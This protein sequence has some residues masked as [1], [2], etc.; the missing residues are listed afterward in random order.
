MDMTSL[1]F[2]TQRCTFLMG[3]YSQRAESVVLRWRPALDA[4]SGWQRACMSEWFVTNLEQQDEIISYVSGN[5]SYARAHLNFTRAPER[6]MLDYMLQSTVM[7]IVSWL[8]FL[9]D[10]T[11]TPARVTLGM[12][13]VLV[14]LQNYIALSQALP[15]GVHDAWLG[16]FVLVSF[17]FNIAAFIEQVLVSFGLQALTWREQSEV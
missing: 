10:P 9:I 4:L 3:L 7:V 12:L 17:F 5:F 1:P 11:Q 14:V 13:T 8:G 15:P 2:D 16:K 6:F